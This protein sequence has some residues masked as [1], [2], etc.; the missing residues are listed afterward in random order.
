MAKAC[1]MAWRRTFRIELSGPALSIIGAPLVPLDI[2]GSRLQI[3]MTA[4]NLNKVHQNKIINFFKNCLTSLNPGS[5]N[6]NQ[7]ILFM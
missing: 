1:N 3:V 4:V 5:N 6:I 2:D 7:F